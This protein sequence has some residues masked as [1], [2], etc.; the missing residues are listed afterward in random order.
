VHKVVCPVAECVQNVLFFEENGLP[1]HFRVAHKKNLKYHDDQT[2][3]R[4]YGEETL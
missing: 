4:M 1:Q 2:M 3:K